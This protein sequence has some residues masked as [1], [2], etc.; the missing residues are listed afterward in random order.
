MIS[1]NAV[2]LFQTKDRVE[3]IEN[4]FQTMVNKTKSTVDNIP[5]LDNPTVKLN[6]FKVLGIQIIS[7]P[8]NW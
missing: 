2:N 1:I 4:N 5:T 6:S 7:W 3:R 8:G